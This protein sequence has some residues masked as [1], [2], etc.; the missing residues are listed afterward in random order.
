MRRG[1]TRIV[2]GILMVLTQCISLAGNAKSG[3]SIRFSTDTLGV[4]LFDLGT[5]ISYFFVGIVG[6]ILLVSGI[7]AYVKSGNS[8]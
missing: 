1:K 4:M 2:F 5:I 7:I 3:V 6:A 8:Q